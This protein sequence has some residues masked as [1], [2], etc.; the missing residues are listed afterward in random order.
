MKELNKDQTMKLI[1][2]RE[3]A[4]ATGKNHSDVLDDIRR[5]CEQA[6]VTI[7]LLIKKENS[8]IIDN[9]KIIV[10]ES[11]Y[12][13]KIEINRSRKYKEYL[14]NKMAAEVLSLGYSVKRRIKILK[15]FYKME[16]TLM[17]QKALPDF[18]NPVIAARAWADEVEKKQLAEKKLELS[19]KAGVEIEERLEESKEVIKKQS[20]D[21]KY[22]EDVLA[23]KNCWTT[24]TVAKAL[25]IK[26]ARELNRILH[27]KGVQYFID[28]HWVLYAKHLGY[29]KTRTKTITCTDGSTITRID[30]LWTEIG[31]KFIRDL[32]DKNLFSK[33]NGSFK[34]NPKI[35]H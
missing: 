8:F 5:M 13:V 31:R 9:Q 14:L 26:S 3:I 22:V 15:L 35:N 6:D 12:E 21:V 16:E 1:S 29:T 34:D 25:G 28:N 7:L 30:T 27:E 11:E 4:E 2:S 33:Q 23:G 20:S 10:I 19:E 18:E 32:L 24:T 17:R